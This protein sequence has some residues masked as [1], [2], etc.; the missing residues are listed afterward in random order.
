MKE[1]A[2]QQSTYALGHSEQELERLDQQ[3]QFFKPFTRQLF[4][5]AGL[6]AGMRVLDVGS[7]A[8]DVA[9]LVAELVGPGGEVIGADRGADAV[10]WATARARAKNIGNV[11]FL[12]GDPTEMQFDRPFDA[13]VGRLVL[14]FYPD[15][16][17]AVRKLAG[18]VREEGLI[19]F[20]EFDLANARSVPQSPTF[21]HH[22]N[23]IK[24]TL[25]ATGARTQ[26]GL[27]MYSVFL[28]AGLSGPTMRMDAMVGGGPDVPAYELV[29]GVIRSL[30]PAMEKLNI[31]TAA[32]VDV[33]TLA[34]RIRDEVVAA[35]GVL[36]SPGLIGSWVRRSA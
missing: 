28:A 8:G 7:G 1:T 25:S 24:Q 6:A 34:Q 29:A 30:L 4:Q 15:P 33:S 19:I 23:L 27:E 31:A 16:V 21:E 13:V 36:V 20:Q 35:K 22:V 17:A 18:H 14:M 5:Q 11:R 3:A 2:N 26:Q 9:F 10:Q 12:E 32:E